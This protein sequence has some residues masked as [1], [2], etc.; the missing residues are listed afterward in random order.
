[1][2]LL[3][4]IESAFAA[5]QGCI[6]NVASHTKNAF[7]IIPFGFLLSVEKTLSMAIRNPKV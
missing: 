2:N 4:A 7:A 6:Q 1:M 3:E 5:R